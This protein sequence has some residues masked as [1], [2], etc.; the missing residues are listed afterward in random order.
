MS[1]G[2]ASKVI[3]AYSTSFSLAS[4]L[5]PRRM[6]SDI[7]N[8]YAVVR[9]ADEIVDGT[10][11]AAGLDAATIHA[12]L[13]GF[14]AEIYRAIDSGFSTN[15]AV[16]AFAM[17]ARRAGIKRDHIEAFFHSMRADIDTPGGDKT[18]GDTATSE[19][20]LHVYSPEQLRSYIYGS[21][22][23]IGLMCLDIFLSDNP[24]RPAHYAQ[25]QR[26]ARA[27]GAAFQ[28]VNFLRDYAHDRNILGR[29]YFAQSEG[30]MTDAIRDE[31]IADIAHDLDVARETVA[32]LPTAPRAAVTAALLLFNEL[33]QRLATADV[34]TERVRVPDA[35][36]A[37]LVAQ[38]VATTAFKRNPADDAESAAKSAAG[39]KDD[40]A[41]DP[42]ADSAQPAQKAVVI[43]GGIAGLASAAFLA[44]EGFET[45]VYEKNDTIGG[46]AG[47]LEDQGFTWDT[48]P[49]WYLMPEAFDHFFE[50]FGTSAQELLDLR[51]LSPAYRVFSSGFEPVD[52]H[53]GVE[54]VAELFES[55]EPGAGEKI[56]EYLKVATQTYHFAIDRFL[57]TTFSSFSDFVNK[58][59]M[60]HAVLL[61]KLLSTPLS[62]WVGR[63]FS[64]IRLRHILE[65]PAVFLS[66]EP[67]RT[68]AMY[69][70]LSHT[71][72][73]EGVR[74]PMGGFS[75][76]IDAVAGVAR[77]QGAKIVTG[78]AVQG[79]EVVDGR[80]RGVRLAAANPGGEPERVDA[81]VVVGAADVN[82]LAGMLG[83]K[84]K[85]VDPGIGVVLGFVGVRG[86][87][88]ELSHHQLFLE[89]E[90]QRDFEA[91]FPKGGA[92][93]QP[94]VS[95][96]I[97]VCKPS[98][99][100][101]SVAPE[102]CEN[103]FILIPTRADEGLLGD[104][105][106]LARQAAEAL[107]DKAIGAIGQR[108]G[109]PDLADRVIVRHA[110]GP[111]DFASRFNAY[112]GN[113]LGYAHTLGQ[114][115]FLRGTQ[116]DPDVS[117][118]LYA[119]ATTTPG[120]GLPMC[121]ISAENLLECLD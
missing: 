14:E 35:L 22:E 63:D 4:R 91:I 38:A 31:I 101:P 13:D 28:K 100:D 43:G 60:A 116:Q 55:I 90:W 111:K 45:T 83:R 119:G 99:T 86:V 73:V 2:A 57:Y 68:P 7:A 66:C 78:R 20:R 77:A 94:G 107:V 96:S 27:L 109:V 23:V 39:W 98:E 65:Y 34:E 85:Q 92:T 21:A 64:D 36:K 88:P 40:V 58:A 15:P 105:A 75:K 54:Q 74:Y 118:L 47:L 120:V 79:I 30:G 19:R 11:A 32:L 115:A 70:L 103:L 82:H 42:A 80:A 72:L 59:T 25:A 106:A 10:A 62:T 67:T 69:H 8:L 33:N 110:M 84:E 52:V 44:R 61:A 112:K 102:G 113:A 51:Q 5:L 26:G 121:L 56:R 87:L 50:Q 9:I 17:T 104:D 41:G 81:D 18:S 1:A 3:G 24:L 6:R 93:A 37:R 48:G 89:R 95:Q 117:G 49:S 12:E 53:S 76:I 97:Y 108:A 16:Q 29:V 114:S 71:D 46:R